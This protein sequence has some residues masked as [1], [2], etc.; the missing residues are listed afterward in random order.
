[1]EP[2]SIRYKNP[3]AMWGNALAIKWGAAKKAVTLNDGKG[4]GNNIAVF[5]TFVQGIC[6]QMDL[7]RTSKNYRN[8]KFEDAIAIWCGHNSTESYIS[9]VT[10]RVP[11]MT[12]DTVMDDAFWRGSMAIGFLK[13]QAGHE[14]GKVYPAPDGDWIEAQKRVLSGVPTSNTVKK[15]AASVTAGVVP[16]VAAGTQGGL[17]F[18]TALLIGLGIALV[19][20]LVVKFKPGTSAEAKAAVEVPHPALIEPSAENPTAQPPVIAAAPGDV[21]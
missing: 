11:G 1:M 12:R 6:A 7:W 13:A 4:Q 14:A 15:A 8:K 10:A 21:K 16:A 19:V 5:P 18:L 3:G 17:S 20:F 9:F 2:A